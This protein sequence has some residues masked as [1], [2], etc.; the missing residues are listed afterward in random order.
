MEVVMMVCFILIVSIFCVFLISR[1]KH[2]NRKNN[3]N[4]EHNNNINLDEEIIYPVHI[5]HR[6]IENL[7]GNFAYELQRRQQIY[8]CI[9]D[10]KI[11]ATLL[12]GQETDLDVLPGNH[13]VYFK[14]ISNMPRNKF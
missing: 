4:L 2:I 12:D 9:I 3:I 13:I 11:V 10:D 7:S 1:P 14:T 6:K 5:K 8:N